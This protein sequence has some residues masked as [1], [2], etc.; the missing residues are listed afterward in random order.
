[1]VV[2]ALSVEGVWKGFSCDGRWTG[3]LED[4]SFQVGQ[5]EVVAIV[6]GRLRGKTTLLKI[7]AGIERPDRGEVSLGSQRLAGLRERAWARLLGHEI[8]W[9]DRDGP[10]I[11]V[12]VSRFV[13]W[14]LALHGRGARYSERMAARALERVGAQECVGR[15]WAELSN[16]QR[17]LVGLARGFAG[18]PRVV[19]I[20]DLLDA[21]SGRDTEEASDLLRSLVQESEPRCGVLMSASEEDTA[22]FADQE[23]SLTRKGRLK[24]LSGRPSGGADVKPFPRPAESQDSPGVGCP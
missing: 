16:W 20:D 23:Y 6:G 18:T 14:P 21:L 13:G 19:I 5:G 24:L 12:E 8:V 4:V 3:V 2:E 1:M 10:K 11:E 22:I 17:V 7:A 9:I 15:R